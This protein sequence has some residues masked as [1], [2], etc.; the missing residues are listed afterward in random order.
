MLLSAPFLKTQI[1]QLVPTVPLGSVYFTVTVLSQIC[2]P[3]SQGKAVT[4][5]D[6]APDLLLADLN[7]A[8]E[9][10]ISP[11]LPAYLPHQAS[12]KRARTER[13]LR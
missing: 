5:S 8:V 2:R 6:V 13:R 7:S 1:W 4:P 11:P 12:I 10:S 3:L 9:A